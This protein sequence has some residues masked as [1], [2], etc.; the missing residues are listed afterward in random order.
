VAATRQTR[1]NEWRNSTA[2]AARTQTRRK[3]G[4]TNTSQHLA[5]RTVH[6]RRGVLHAKKTR[7]TMTKTKQQRTCSVDRGATHAHECCNAIAT[8]KHAQTTPR[9]RCAASGAAHKHAEQR[10]ASTHTRAA[11]HT[12]TRTRARMLARI[13]Q[14]RTGGAVGSMSTPCAASDTF[15]PTAGED[16]TPHHHNLLAFRHDRPAAEKGGGWREK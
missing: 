12:K 4:A 16:T 10:P 15:A 3:R 9:G 2:R 8:A 1:N 6:R 14:S 5:Q 13:T 7:Q 11:A